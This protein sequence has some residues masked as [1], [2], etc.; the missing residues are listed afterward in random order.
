[1]HAKGKGLMPAQAFDEVD[2]EAIRLML[3]GKPKMYNQWYS[4]QCSGWCG[5]GKNLKNWRR[6]DDARCPNCNILVED[7]GHLMMCRCPDR[8]RLF[9][10]HVGMIEEWMES[11]FTHPFLRQLVGQ[12]LRGRGTRKFKDLN[13]NTSGTK[14]LAAAQDKIGCKHFLHGGKTSS[15]SQTNPNILP[16]QFRH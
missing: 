13:T 4:K 14:S 9:E 15:A 7:A 6:T 3:A 8:S 12:Y 10:E 2:W 16:L 1:M 5:T 11:H